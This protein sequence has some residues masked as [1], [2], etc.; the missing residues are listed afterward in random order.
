[1]ST[2]ETGRR[3]FARQLTDKAQGPIPTY[4]S[5]KFLM[6]DDA[7]KLGSMAVAAECWA[8]GADTLEDDLRREIDALQIGFKAGEDA[9]YREAA[10][11]HRDRFK[12]VVIGRYRGRRTDQI[13]TAAMPRPG[14]YVGGP[15]TG[16]RGPA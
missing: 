14:D 10:T 16:E 15:V 8:A 5:K 7:T 4:G 3:Y 6:A 9:T 2:P 1:M 12:H 13:D 11:A